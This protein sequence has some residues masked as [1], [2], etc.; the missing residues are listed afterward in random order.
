MIADLLDQSWGIQGVDK[1]D[2]ISGLSIL[3]FWIM[4]SFGLW[5]SKKEIISKKIVCFFNLLR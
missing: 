3:D 1:G 5:T 2:E 4:T